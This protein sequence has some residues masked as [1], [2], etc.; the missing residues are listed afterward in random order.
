MGYNTRYHLTYPDTPFD[1][2]DKLDQE[3]EEVCEDY[4]FVAA[5]EPCKWYD[6]E[7]DLRAFSKSKPGLLL[8]LKGEGEEAGDLWV[9]YFRDGLMQECRAKIVYPEMDELNWR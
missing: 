3:L 8:K 2:V 4:G 5:G 1:Q 7:D 9:K 6:H